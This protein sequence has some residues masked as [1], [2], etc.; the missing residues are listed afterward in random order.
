[1]L[2]FN[3]IVDFMEKRNIS[4]ALA[5]LVIYIVFGLLILVACIRFLPNLLNDLQEL[6]TNFPPIMPGKPMNI[7]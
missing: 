1:M 5:I 7:Y 6:G 3:P 4:R 2:T